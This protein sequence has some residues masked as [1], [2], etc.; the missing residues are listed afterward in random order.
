ML[1]L[2]TSRASEP[3]K[4]GSLV[5][6]GGGAIPDKVRDKFMSL[7]GGKAARLLIIPTA[8]SAADQRREDEG[9]L[10]P[11]RPYAPA[12]LALLH[13]RSRKKAD[14]A[15]F[16]KPIKDATAVWFG[17]GDQIELV[18]P[19]LGTAVERELRTSC[20]AVAASSAARRP[21]RQ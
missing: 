6:V 3:V 18:A 12:G 21:A 11:W 2:P 5:I 19:Y 15:Q 20:W 1:M 13:T 9:Y 4:P 7:A 14:D 8:S 10:K 16:V 17:G